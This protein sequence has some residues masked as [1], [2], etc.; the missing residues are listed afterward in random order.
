[1]IVDCLGRLNLLN[2]IVRLENRLLFWRSKVLVKKYVFLVQ[3]RFMFL[4]V[5]SINLTSLYRRRFKSISSAA[6]RLFESNRYWFLFLLFGRV[7][8]EFYTFLIWLNSNE[9]VWGLSIWPDLYTF[10]SWIELNLLLVDDTMMH[11]YSSL[12]IFQLL[13]CYLNDS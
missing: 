4:D 9:D 11:D 6:Y 12:I 8:R 13:Y 5:F 1:L 3:L 2:L 10:T 7:R